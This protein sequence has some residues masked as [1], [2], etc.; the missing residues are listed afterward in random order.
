MNTPRIYTYK[1]TFEEVPYYYYGV[2]KEKK[3]NEYYM[4]SPVTNKWCCDFYTPEKQILE[5]F[6]HTESVWLEAQEV[7][8][9]LIKPVFTND[10]WCLNRSC[11]GIVSMDQL[12]KGGKKTYELKLGVHNLTREQLIEIGKKTPKEQLIQNGKKVYE[13]K[14]GAHSLTRKQLIENGRK[15]AIITQSQKWQCTVTG[16]VSTPG[17]LSSYQK[18]RNINTSNRI[19]IQ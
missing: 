15:G 9:R 18:A 14:L 2:H 13:L 6:P 11:G 3:F 7:E 5:F 16:H 1:I 10:G 12:I 17:G 8:T 19:R 4:G